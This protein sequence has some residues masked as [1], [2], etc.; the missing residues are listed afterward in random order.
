MP[1]SYRLRGNRVAPMPL[2]RINS[3]AVIVAKYFG[4]NKRNKRKLDKCFEQ[5][6]EIGVTLQVIDDTEWLFVTKGHY[7]PNKAV[8]SVPQSIYLNACGGDRDALAVMLHELGHMSLSHKALLHHTDNDD[9][10]KE[11]DAEW[12]A[13]SFAEKILE[14]MGYETSQLSLD[15]YM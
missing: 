7:D 9:V 11:E 10:C 15:F 13:D 4:F 12:Q 3:V 1:E 5:L 6:S 14:I 8:I 2:S